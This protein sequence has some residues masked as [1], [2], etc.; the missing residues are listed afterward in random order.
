MMSS[1][2]YRR[3]DAMPDYPP[4]RPPQQSSSE[5]TWQTW[6]QGFSR[7]CDEYDM[8]E[9]IGEGTYG[10]V[11]KA[12]HRRKGHLVAMKKMRVHPQKKEDSQGYPLTA[13][14]EIKILKRLSHDNM[15]CM[16][17]VVTSNNARRTFDR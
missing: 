5:V 2:L 8:I 16:H 17:E 6:G 4:Q 9:K 7:T 12:R 1:A 15:V 10:Q 13:V 11:Y 3:S 14:R